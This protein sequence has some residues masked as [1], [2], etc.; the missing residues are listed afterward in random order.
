MSVETKIAGFA[1]L[2]GE[3][4]PSE[5]TI[6]R[7]LEIAKL[8]QSRFDFT[9]YDATLLNDVNIVVIGRSGSDRRR[10]VTVYWDDI[11]DIHG[12]SADGMGGITGLDFVEALN[13][14]YRY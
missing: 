8:M 6:A 10:E 5:I 13:R 1:H 12:Y 4:K 9:A 7:A 11:V 3:R 14:L 2:P